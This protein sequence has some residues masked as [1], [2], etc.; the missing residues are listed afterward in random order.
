MTSALHAADAS[1][2]AT[3]LGHGAHSGHHVCSFRLFAGVFSALLFLT[4]I[5]VIVSRFDFGGFNMIIA[6]AIAA[7]KASLVMSIF[8]H[9]R[10]DTAINNIAFLSS[11]LFLSLLFL[12]T[13]A[14]YATRGDTDPVLATPS[15][16]MK[17]A[18]YYQHDWSDH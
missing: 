16:Q 4:I 12:F 3:E 7:V 8:M 13:L 6:M 2:H 5:T 14:D 10:W 15:M 11:I 9:M 1:E 18:E 17:P